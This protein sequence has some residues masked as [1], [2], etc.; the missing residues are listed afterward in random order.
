[1]PY[2]KSGVGATPQWVDELPKVEAIETIED[3]E[4]IE[5]A[6][7]TINPPEDLN[8]EESVVY[9]TTH[10]GALGLNGKF[11]T[12]GAINLF[13]GG[14][15]GGGGKFEDAEAREIANPSFHTRLKS[16]MHKMVD[17]MFLLSL[18]FYYYLLFM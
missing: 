15:N 6:S 13:A 10:Y 9:C 5:P 11:N 3:I 18:I 12:E 1:M 8:E 4:D 17:S 2:I 7:T 16:L 14:V